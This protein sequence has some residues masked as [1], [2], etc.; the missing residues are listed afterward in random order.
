MEIFISLNYIFKP[1]CDKMK[2]EAVKFKKQIENWFIY[3]SLRKN[4]YKKEKIYENSTLIYFI[5]FYVI[6]RRFYIK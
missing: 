4:P 2:I 6:F 5:S 3:F 1:T